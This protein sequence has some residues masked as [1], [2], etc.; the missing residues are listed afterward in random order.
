MQCACNGKLGTVVS[1][2]SFVESPVTGLHNIFAC[3]TRCMCVKNRLCDA[4]GALILHY[5]LFASK[6]NAIERRRRRRKVHEWL[7]RMISIYKHIC[8]IVTYAS[9][10]QLIF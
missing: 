9:H 7:N 10:S 4:V 3:E 6:E 5:E 2:A 1:H 8:L